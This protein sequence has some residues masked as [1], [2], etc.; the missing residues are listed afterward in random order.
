MLMTNLGVERCTKNSKKVSH[1]EGKAKDLSLFLFSDD[2]RATCSFLNKKETKITV[3]IILHSI[4][5]HLYSHG[6]ASLLSSELD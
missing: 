2:L 6:K 4:G 1:I 5:I 3:A